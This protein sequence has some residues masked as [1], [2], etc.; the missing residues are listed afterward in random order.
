MRSSG[1]ANCGMF[2][3]SSID[4]ELHGRD[5]SRKINEARDWTDRDSALPFPKRSAGNAQGE[6]VMKRTTLAFRLLVCIGLMAAKSASGATP[7]DTSLAALQAQIDSLKAVKVAWRQIDWKTCL[8]D[9]L[10][11]SRF[12]KKP[13]LLWIFI[14][15]PVDDARC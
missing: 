5:R 7:D 12:Q 10:Q 14:D 1:G 9:G 15:R 8:L 3:A 11:E 6:T 4:F 13:A 2:T